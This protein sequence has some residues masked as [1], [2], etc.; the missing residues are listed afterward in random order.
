MEAQ[1][2]LNPA[3]T[4]IQYT[5]YKIEPEFNQLYSILHPLSALDIKATSN[6]IIDILGLGLNHRYTRLGIKP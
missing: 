2:G 4:S 1:K 3:W 5:V 6:L